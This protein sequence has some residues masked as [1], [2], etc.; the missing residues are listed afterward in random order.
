[1]K[2]A[3]E[4]FLR[5]RNKGLRIAAFGALVTVSALWNPIMAWADGCVCG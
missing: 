3:T 4:V 5:P 2:R 1:M